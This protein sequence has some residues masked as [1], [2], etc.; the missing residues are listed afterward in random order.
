MK[1]AVSDGWRLP[2]WVEP[3]A[4]FLP[5][6]GTPP[7]LPPLSALWTLTWLLLGAWLLFLALK[8]LNVRL[9]R[10][11]T[12]H[13]PSFWT[14]VVLENN[15][16]NRTMVVFPVLLINR[17]LPV[18]PQLPINFVDGLQRLTLATLAVIA[19]RVIGAVVD[20][21]HDIYQRYPI[22]EG[23]PIKGYVQVFKLVLYIAAGLMALAALANQSPW[24]FISGLGAMTAIILLIF[25]DTILSFV[26]GV[27][28]V[29]N[30]LV[31]VGDWIEMP[32]FNADGDVVDIA[33]NVVRVQNWDRTITVIP[34]HKFLEHAFKNWRNMFE[35]GGR[36][37]KRTLAIDMA[38]VRFLTSEEI[39][40]FRRFL[41]LHDYIV[42]KEEDIA[43]WN[44]ANCP[45]DRTDVV[46][47]TRHLTNLGTLRAYILEYLRRNPYI[48]QESTVMVR[49]M[50]PGSQGVGLQIYV[51]CR[52]TA[53]VKYEGIQ[54]DIF[55]HILAIV[56]E[57]SLRIFQE[58]TGADF[59]KSWPG[60]H[61]G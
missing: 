25:R 14:D 15:I 22:A 47:N 23:R 39:S 42:A 51:F 11:L 61:R 20:A 28:L 56:P 17:G 7:A 36:R 38:S 19:A 8:T 41:L 52:E 13:M 55:D 34:T 30:D 4:A 35:T 32:Q 27:Q 18:I 37:I 54:S 21:G 24:F 9:T 31:R 60:D 2:E 49:Q 46:A 29:N 10:L 48:D 53:W 5:D 12:R 1:L 43:T 40:R 58:P 57:F 6:W 45:G 50:E 59:G 3:L 44:E 26:A 16:L 33:L